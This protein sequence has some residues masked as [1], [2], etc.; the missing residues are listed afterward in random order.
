MPF[1]GA[2]RRRKR[3][4]HKAGRCPRTLFTLGTLLQFSELV[5][6]GEIVYAD[7][8]RPGDGFSPAQKCRAPAL[9]PWWHGVLLKV[10]GLGHLVLL[11]LVVVLS[12][13]VFQGSLWRTGTNAPWQDGGE[14]QGRNHTER[15]VISALMRYFC[16]PRCKSPAACSGCKLCPQDWRL[17]GDRCYQLSKEKGNWNQGKKGCKNQGSH[18]VVLR[19]KKEKEYIRNVT[20]GGTQP[21]WIG[22]LSSHSKWRWV[23]NTPFNTSSPPCRR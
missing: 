22:L 5:M 6:A 16:Q 14:T 1:P 20:G 12:V 8:R 21:V 9:C 11:V 15:C 19:D 2:R 3:I 10:G 13:Q 23:D 7:L 17:H 4:G 18:L